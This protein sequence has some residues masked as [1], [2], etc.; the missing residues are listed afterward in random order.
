MLCRNGARC[1][2]EPALPKK[3]DKFYR[4]QGMQPA[5]NARPGLAI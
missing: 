3:Y 4:E 2:L 1:K 5:P